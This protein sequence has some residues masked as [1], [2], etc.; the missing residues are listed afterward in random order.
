MIKEILHALSL[1]H[2]FNRAL[3]HSKL[4]FP[5]KFL[6]TL[7]SLTSIQNFL[8]LLLIPNEANG[9]KEGYVRENREVSYGA[10]RGGYPLDGKKCIGDETKKTPLLSF[11]LHNRQSDSFLL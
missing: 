9:E 5:T 11:I 10:K 1:P 8:Q 6:F 3:R 7:E 4:E 2:L